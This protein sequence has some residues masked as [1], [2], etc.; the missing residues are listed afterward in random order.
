MRNYINLAHGWNIE[1][2]D[3][4]QPPSSHG[5]GHINGGRE[6]VRWI[7]REHTGRDNERG[8]LSIHAKGGERYHESDVEQTQMA[9]L[10]DADF[11]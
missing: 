4:A 3:G 7:G 11:F 10:L 8:R 1:D 5:D 6:G 9:T 2:G